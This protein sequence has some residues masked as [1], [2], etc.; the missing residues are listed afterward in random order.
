[1]PEDSES[2]SRQALDEET[3]SR[4]TLLDSSDCDSFR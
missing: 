1:M 4:N 3:F 2:A